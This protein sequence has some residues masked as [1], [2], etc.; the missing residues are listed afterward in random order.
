MKSKQMAFLGVILKGF[1]N[2]KRKEKEKRE[3][4][5]YFFLSRH[6]K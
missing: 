5:K 3:R 4:E 6:N 2:K 1:V